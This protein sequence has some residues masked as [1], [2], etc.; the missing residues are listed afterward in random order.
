MKPENICIVLVEP[1]G[2]LNIGSVCRSMMNLG[3]SDLRLV[4][5]EADHLGLEARKMALKAGSLLHSAS[6]HETLGEALSDVNLAFGT[7]RRFGKYREDFQPADDAADHIL[8]LPDSS[9]AALV[10]GR[11]DRGLHT[12]ELDHCQ[13]FI[14]LP[15]LE[16][17]ASMNLSQAATLCMYE[18]RKKLAGGNISPVTRKE[19]AAAEDQERMFDHMRQTLLDIEYLNPQN[20]DHLMRT[21]RRIFGRAELDER[22]IRVLQ[23]LWARIDWV[24]GD[25][26][27]KEKEAGNS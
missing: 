15:T 22:E 24:E 18:I 2:P 5:P 26:R 25:R 17:F 11:E 14:T 6:V 23:G 8:S 16:A 12:D 21:F 3:F 10:F 9:R 20:P 19:P 13:Q 4:A 1:Q 27:K 7:T